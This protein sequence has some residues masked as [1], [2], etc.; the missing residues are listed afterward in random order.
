MSIRQMRLQIQKV[1]LPT[2]SSTIVDNIYIV[3]IF[4]AIDQ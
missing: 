1:Y 3:I 2:Y 4:L